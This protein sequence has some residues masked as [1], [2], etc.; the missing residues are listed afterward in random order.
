MKDLLIGMA[1]GVS[2]ASAINCPKTH[3][4]I[5]F[6]EKKMKD[7]CDAMTQ[8]KDGKKE[9]NSQQNSC[10]CE[11]GCDCVCHEEEIY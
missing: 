4:F 6:A 7:I 9:E 2:L 11:C 5:K 1:L 8:K 10:E 3:E